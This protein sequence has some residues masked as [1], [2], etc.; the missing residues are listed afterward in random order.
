MSVHNE[1]FYSLLPARE[2]PLGD[3]FTKNHLFHDV[4]SDWH[5]ILTDIK[6]STAAVAKGQNQNVNLIATGSI[7]TVLNLAYKAN[8]TVPFFFGGDG[9]TFIVPASILNDSM[10]A[11]Q[12][13]QRNT[14]DNFKMDLRAG[15]MPVKE[16]YDKGLNLRI[17]K[18]RSSEHLSIPI[19]LGNGLN[20][21]EEVI[22]SRDSDNVVEN[23]RELDLT[24]MECRWDK[25]DPP[26]KNFEIVTL[27]AI[28][29][30]EAKQPIAF[31]KVIRLLDEIYGSPE[32]RQPISVSKLKLKTSFSR[33]E[34]GLLAR[35][36]KAGFF[37]VVNT[38][39]TYLLAYFYFETQKG[40]DYLTRL[41][42]M[43]DTLV[44]DGRINTVITGTE[45]QRLKLAESLNQLEKEGLITFGLYV[46]QESV[47]SCYVRDL[48]DDHIH[49]VD[50][51]DGGYTNAAGIIKLK[52]KQI[53]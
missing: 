50:G 20:Y 48:Q 24:G 6:N 18:Y 27:L 25:I 26:E 52:N 29:K 7:V 44:I 51:S 45:T 4:P 38:W 47:M 35:I 49:F 53:V 10:A 40:K 17:S 36:N 2:I 30:D 8:I 42:T 14:L 11:L 12:I 19:A 34:L 22:K 41:V 16:I 15:T 43:S 37:K 9:A 5:V 3:L 31:Q 21:A 23:E 28:S 32:R 1:Q 46:S 13:F 33:I 39:L